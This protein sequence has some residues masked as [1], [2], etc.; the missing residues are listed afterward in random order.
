MKVC[1]NTIKWLIGF[2]IVAFILAY[3]VSLNIENHFI[4]VNS[5]WISNDFLFA[6]L[7]GAFASLL[8]VLALEVL[9]YF[10]LRKETEDKLFLCFMNLYDSVLQTRTICKRAINGSYSITGSMLRQTTDNAILNL[11]A[12]SYLDYTSFFKKKNRISRFLVCFKQEKY[13]SIKNTLLDFLFFHLA[14][15]EDQIDLLR[16][17]KTDNV[18]CNSTNTNKALKKIL[19][20]SADLL[21]LIDQLLSNIDDELGNRYNWKSIKQTM[22]T[23]QDNYTSKCLKDYLLEDTTVL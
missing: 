4:H 22:N 8:I 17:G 7:G 11:N 6:I 13:V 10:Q 19:C 21:T 14:V 23:C 2:L 16:Q 20:Q 9:K 18:T 15:Q 1:V 3:S 5:K 12:I